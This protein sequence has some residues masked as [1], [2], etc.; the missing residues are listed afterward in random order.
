MVLADR[1]HRMAGGRPRGE[2][3]ALAEGTIRRVV[4]AVMT[5]RERDL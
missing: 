5:F 3:P 1:P 4:H 2:P